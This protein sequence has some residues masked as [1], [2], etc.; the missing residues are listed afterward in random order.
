MDWVDPPPWNIHFI[1]YCEGER[2]SIHVRGN[3]GTITDFNP[4]EDFEVRT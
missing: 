4:F 2:T 3:D 1:E